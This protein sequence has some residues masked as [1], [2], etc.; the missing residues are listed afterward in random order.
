MLYSTFST[1]AHVTAAY[2]GVGPRNHASARAK[3][4]S[5][6]VGLARP[7]SPARPLAG[8]DCLCFALAAWRGRRRT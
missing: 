2:V 4:R 6:L 5:R 1:R 8:V 3:A 7:P